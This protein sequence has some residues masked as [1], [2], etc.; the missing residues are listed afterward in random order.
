MESTDRHEVES[1]SAA[2]FAARRE[3]F[4]LI[5]A[6]LA[7]RGFSNSTPLRPD[8]LMLQSILPLRLLHNQLAVKKIRFDRYR[9]EIIFEVWSPQEPLI[10]PFGIGVRDN[11]NLIAACV[12]QLSENPVFYFREDTGVTPGKSPPQIKPAILAKPGTPSTLTMFG[13][14]VRI[15]MSVLPLQSGTKGQCIFVRDA[16][17][18]RVLKAEVT[19]QNLL[20]ANF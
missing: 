13:Q 20:Q 19:D 16:S 14:N 8:D 1:P 11:P 17:T 2:S 18:G 4:D 7:R 12:A 5:Q 15:T 3:V 10:P 9:R 6:E